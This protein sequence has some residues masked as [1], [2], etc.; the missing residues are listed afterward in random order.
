MLSSFLYRAVSQNKELKANI[1]E[2]QDA[3]VHL[4]HQN[5]ELASELETKKN[6]LFQ[7]KSL[8]ILTPQVPLETEHAQINS[9]IQQATPVPQQT[10]PTL[11]QTTP[12]SQQPTPLPAS[13]SITLPQANEEEM[14]RSVSEMEETESDRDGLAKEHQDLEVRRKLTLYCVSTLLLVQGPLCV[15]LV[16]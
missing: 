12:T 3:F 11:Q 2:L 14:N 13:E 6:H 4:S 5:M 15:Y 10:T 1:A 16:L 8:S 7:M 9:T